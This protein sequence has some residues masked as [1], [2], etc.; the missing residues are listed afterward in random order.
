MGQA[1]LLRR[2]HCRPQAHDYG[3]RGQAHT[4]YLSPLILRRGDW[5]T[6]RVTGDKAPT[7]W[8][9]WD[10]Q[11][12]L[13]RMRGRGQQA[14]GSNCPSLQHRH[15]FP[16]SDQSMARPTQ[17]DSPQSRHRHT[18]PSPEEPDSPG[19]WDGQGGRR[20]WQGPTEV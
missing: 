4:P 20:P 10:P 8:G 5:N 1:P 12:F 15:P 14:M 19:R 9:T 3:G 18:Q 17:N 16:H 2:E 13:E 11:T 6:D 7:Q